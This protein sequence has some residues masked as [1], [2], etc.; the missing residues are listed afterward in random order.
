MWF[1]MFIVLCL[2]AALFASKARQS[3][4]VITRAPELVEM[5]QSLKS[6]RGWVQRSQ[7][8][9]HC[10]YDCARCCCLCASLATHP[11]PRLENMTE[12]QKMAFMQ[13][14]LIVWDAPITVAKD[15]FWGCF[16]MKSKERIEAEEHMRRLYAPP[17]TLT[18]E[19]R[20]RLGVAPR[21]YAKE[22]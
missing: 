19:E 5:N 18:P 20:E 8:C 4:Q 3:H 2:P 7:D 13:L 22:D 17:H 15:I 9:A 12:H 11:C 16:C 1:K 6:T 14:K 10:C 21:W